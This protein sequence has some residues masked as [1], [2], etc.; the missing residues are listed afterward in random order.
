[1]TVSLTTQDLVIAAMAYA[2]TGRPMAAI[3]AP[4]AVRY[5]RN[6]EEFR[7]LLTVQRGKRPAP[8][9]IQAYLERQRA[10][11]RYRPLPLRPGRG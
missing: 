4:L 6:P 1:M 10:R 9:E 3:L 8:P 2:M 7:S 11:E 5:I